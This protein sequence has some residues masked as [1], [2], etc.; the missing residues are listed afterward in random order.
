MKATDAHRVG[1]IRDDRFL[2]HKTGLIHPEHPNRLKAIHAMLDRDFA[3]GLIHIQA[4]LATMD[5]LEL[6]HTPTYI[7]KVM[8]TAER[9]FTHLAPDTPASNMT[10]L[11]AWL[12]VGGC[13]KALEALMTGRCDS[14]F[15]F[16]RPPGHHAVED[17]AL[18]FC[19]FNNLGIAARKAL[20]G[21][22]LGRILIVD[23][24]I[25]HGNGLQQLFYEDPR[26]LYFSS[27][28]LSSYPATGDWEETGQGDGLGYTINVPI[29]KNMEDDD[30][31]HCYREILGPVVRRYR[32]ELILVAAG[33]DAHG[34]D[35][36]GHARL[37]ERAFG[38]LTR[39][40]MDLREENGRP[41]VLLALEGGYDLPA[42]A[43]S[44]HEVLDALLGKAYPGEI[45]ETT[46]PAGA[47]M[48]A[49]AARVHA[50]FGIWTDAAVAEV[51]A[52]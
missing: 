13:L 30:I 34:A 7:K 38:R 37:T 52:S 35:P 24:D 33:F 5:E 14:V 21:F 23:W 51:G 44:V 8:K 45:Q 18:G 50:E 20:Q 41:P 15:A 9:E 2:E 17:R 43:A 16:V 39:L 27:H 46:T 48:A 47:D 32:P 31:V 3:S 4:D 36:M 29:P 28:Y 11:A 6:V 25:H 40:I 22:S 42:L 19:I 26:V 49:R 1:I 10:Y 12:A